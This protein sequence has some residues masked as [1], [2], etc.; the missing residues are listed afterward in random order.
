MSEDSRSPEGRVFDIIRHMK[1]KTFVPPVAVAKEAAQGLKFRDTFNR[2]GTWVGIARGRD[3]K[4]R[5]ELSVST[6][7]RMYSYFARHEIDKLGRNFGNNKN[8]SNGYIAWLLWGGDPGQKWA[9]K[10]YGEIKNDEKYMSGDS[11]L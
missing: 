1:Q 3:L 4:N 8:P 6:I 7:K 5:R 2:G 11:N 9:R 10:M